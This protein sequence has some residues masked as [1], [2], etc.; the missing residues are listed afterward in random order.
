MH[1]CKV[2]LLGMKVPKP[3]S[4]FP[5]IYSKNALPRLLHGGSGP[6]RGPQEAERLFPGSA[7]NLPA[8]PGHTWL[9]QNGGPPRRGGSW[10]SGAEPP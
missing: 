3:I 8:L 9:L 1:G 2:N 10:A 7:Q 4:S 6:A 5:C